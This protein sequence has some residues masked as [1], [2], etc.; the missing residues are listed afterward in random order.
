MPASK[1]KLMIITTIIIISLCQ[2]SLYFALDKTEFNY[3]KVILFLLILLAYLFILPQVFSPEYEPGGINCGMPIL[4]IY[5]AFW[6]FGGGSAILIHL[7]YL[8]TNK[9]LNKS[10]EYLAEKS[11][12]HLSRN[13]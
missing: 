9:L 10:D 6:I 5:I 2:V 4:G 11:S 13:N 8:L 1:I 12:G 3:G 7:I